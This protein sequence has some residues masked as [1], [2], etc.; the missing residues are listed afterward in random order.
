MLDGQRY[1]AIV[2]DE[3]PEQLPRLRAI[4]DALSNLDKAFRQHCEGFRPNYPARAAL[5]ACRAASGFDRSDCANSS[6][7]IVRLTLLTS[8]LWL[9]PTPDGTGEA[10]EKSVGRALMATSRRRLAFALSLMVAS[11][12]LATAAGAQIARGP[13]AVDKVGAIERVQFWDDRGWSYRNNSWGGR[14]P[15][16][17]SRSYDP[18]APYR[19]QQVYESI[20]PPAPRK[21]ETPPAETVVV[22]GDTFAEWLAYGLEEVFAETPQIG[23]MRRIK[24]DLGLV[25]DDSRLDAPEWTRAIKDLLPATE[26]PNA[27]VVLLG[28]NDRA[29][30]RERPLPAKEAASSSDNAHPSPAPAAAPRPPPSVSYEFHTDKWAELYSK[31][32]DEMIAALKMR[33]V[34]IIWV[35]LPAIRG[36]KSTAD[37]SYLNELYRARADKAGIAYVDVWDAFVDDQGRYVQDGPDFEGQTRRL[38]TY[39]GVYFTK[40]GAEKLGHYVEHDLRRLLGS[41]SVPVALPGS[42]EQSPAKNVVGPV[43]PLNVIGAEKS[44]ELLGTA[45]QSAEREADPLATRVLDRGEALIPPRGRA[46]DF[47]WP[48][49]G[50]SSGA[51][52]M[53]LPDTVPPQ[54][55]TE[56]KPAATKSNEA[57][58]HPVQSAPTPVMVKTAPSR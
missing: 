24:Q 41:Q 14:R 35:A 15:S 5:S 33:G 4:L 25:R 53:E 6:P 49:A 32:I 34:P 39:D 22:I 30:L 51:D 26:K 9:P 10:A 23:I 28:V 17:P 16:Y 56:T 40:A 29:P 45:K 19:R 36:A 1:C 3:V 38:R 37:M 46:D 12:A 20:K 54:R 21:P 50:P 58:K 55:P 7:N 11:F 44:G 48:H 8:I 47:S 27:I 31:R 18:Y 13:L 57:K 52:D 42:E 43:L 2:P